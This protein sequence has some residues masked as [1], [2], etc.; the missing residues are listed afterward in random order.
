MDTDVK[1]MFEFHNV[2][3]GL[4][5]TGKI[6]EFNFVYDCG[7]LSSP[8][9]TDFLGNS[10]KN[11]KAQLNNNYLNLLVISHFH[12]DHVNGLDRLLN[13]LKVDEVIIPYY[14]LIERLILAIGTV[15]QPFW[16]YEFLSNPITFLL[17]RNVE[18][19][20]LI[21][22]EGRNIDETDQ[23]AIG[24]KKVRIEYINWEKE[25]VGE[26]WEFKFFYHY[27]TPKKIAEFKNCLKKNGINEVDIPKHIKNMKKYRII[28]KTCYNKI[29]KQNLNNTSL[30]MYHGPINLNRNVSY[31]TTSSFATL[32]GFWSLPSISYKL[33][34]EFGHFLTG[35][36]NLKSRNIKIYNYYSNVLEK[37]EVTQI[38]HHGS[39]NN[40][41]PRILNDIP[42][43]NLWIASAGILGKNGHPHVDI[44]QELIL[45]NR[46][47][48]W[49]N[50][51]NK[52][53]IEGKI[54][55]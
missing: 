47:F 21:M 32:G 13:G 33:T 52:I 17:E 42:N 18:K 2:G 40:W 39:I 34:K 55:K 23:T 1:F 6:S 29:T 8:Q 28:F 30:L 19:I 16:Y 36:I 15:N 53:T 38:P 35:D 12:E 24:N 46:L 20:V 31:F 48:G 22:D 45:K 43:C 25:L 7:S 27:S 5:Y 54:V 44:I 26:L 14:S 41:K 50:E 10:I 9:K 4:F 51:L 37:I 3:Q 11:Y 49:S